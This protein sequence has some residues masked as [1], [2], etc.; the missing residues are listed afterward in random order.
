M[1]VAITTLATEP[2][3]D[4]LKNELGKP[5]VAHLAADPYRVLR[6]A[7]DYMDLGLYRPSLELLERAYPTVPTEQ[8]EPGSVLPQAHI[9]V[10]YYAAYCRSKLGMD[11]D[12]SWR[13]AARL[14]TALVVPST[15][16]DSEVLEAALQANP[17]DATAHYL[18]GT[19]L[20]SKGMY[21]QGI[22]HWTEAQRL[23]PKLPVVD[24]DL[25]RAWLDLKHDPQQALPYFQR[26]LEND[27]LN[28]A[29]YVGLDEALSLTS[30]PPSER[31]SALSRYPD[32]D[33]PHSTMPE[34]L[35][36]ELALTRAETAK[37][38]QAEELFQGRFFASEEGGITSDEVLLEVELLQAEAEAQ[39]G[40]YSAAKALLA[41]DLARLSKN[42]ASS[43]GYFRMAMVA[44]ACGDPDQATTLLE[45]ATHA[46]RFADRVWAYMAMNSM[47][48]ADAPRAFQELEK[49]LP[50]DAASIDIHSY[51]SYHWYGLGLLQR[52][53]NQP[54]QAMHS[55]QNA[56][57]LPDEWMAHHLSRIAMQQIKAHP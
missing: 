54:D 18:L 57:M 3:S 38:R 52:A 51:T 10:R 24:V 26:A 19:L 5:D 36:Y 45:N 29:V 32:A 16:M 28:P 17:S 1:P 33:S 22:S 50:A 49:L 53:L 43:Q 47:G 41:G 25:G 9:M 56:L 15:A 12:P 23:D 42:G 27:R 6:V 35:T 55:F 44:K 7:T 8:T 40:D 4:F 30:V 37:F 34:S 48:S 13:E 20:F 46:H 21:D 39:S 2:T 11:A 31:E 14:S